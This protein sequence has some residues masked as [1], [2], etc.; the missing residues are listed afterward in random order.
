MIYKFRSMYLD[1][2]KDGAQWA[3]D[4]AP[5]CTCVGRVLRLFRLDEL[6]QLV[7]T[8]RG[9]MSLVGLRPERAVFYEQFEMYIPGFNQRLRAKPGIMGFAQV[10][11]GYNLKPEEK[12]VYDIEYIEKVV[13]AVGPSG[14]VENR[15]SGFQPRRREIA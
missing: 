13:A 15:Q 6:P 4:H 3:Q 9:E 2:E 1:A 11:S 8:L 7:N 10:S 14:V 12:I 5:R